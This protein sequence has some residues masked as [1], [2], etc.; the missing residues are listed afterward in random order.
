M[1]KL[2]K[3]RQDLIDMYIKSLEEGNIPWEQ[4]WKTYIP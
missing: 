1:S 2:P 3:T 4:M